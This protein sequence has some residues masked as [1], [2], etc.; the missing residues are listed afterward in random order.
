TASNP[1]KPSPI[2]SKGTPADGMKRNVW[3]TLTSMFVGSG[4][5]TPANRRSVLKWNGAKCSERE[6]SNIINSPNDEKAAG[7]FT[8]TTVS[9]WVRDGSGPAGPQHGS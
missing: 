8:R 7:L 6:L 5:L 2:A 1:G 9:A 4:P 3:A